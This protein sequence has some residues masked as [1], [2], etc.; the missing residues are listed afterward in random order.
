MNYPHSFYSTTPLF[1]MKKNYLT[2]DFPERH[3]SQIDLP[4]NESTEDSSKT[5]EQLPEQVIRNVETIDYLR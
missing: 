4:A 2:D 1:D 3:L 5:N